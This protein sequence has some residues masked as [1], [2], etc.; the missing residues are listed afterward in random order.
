MPQRQKKTKKQQMTDVLQSAHWRWEFLRRGELY[1]YDYR[2]FAWKYA[3]WI[4]ADFDPAWLA[5]ESLRRSEDPRIAKRG[6]FLN[7]AS[8]DLAQFR[9]DWGIDPT[10]PSSPR[11]PFLREAK[12]YVVNAG[13]ASS[14]WGSD[15]N[16]I[17]LHIDLSGP[18]EEILR[19]LKFR[20]QHEQTR[21]R[22]EVRTKNGTLLQKERRHRFSL[23][24][25]Y[26]RA[27]DLKK[28]GHTYRQIAAEIFKYQYLGDPVKKALAYRN[29]ADFLITNV[30]K[31]NW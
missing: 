16:V 20:V 7:E 1:Q 2:R 3:D 25:N 6:S 19:E 9:K 10:D 17:T 23:Y 13:P 27:W 12:W 18:L 15:P 31:G 4:S 28:A 29:A 22:K 24:P 26:L 14:G 30:Q 21:L 5:Q 8:E 11:S